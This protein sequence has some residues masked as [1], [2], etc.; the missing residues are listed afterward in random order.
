LRIVVIGAGDIGMPV[1]HY[2]SEM[3]NILTVIEKDEKRCKHISDHADAAIFKGNAT[4]PKIWNSIE[5]DKADALFVLTNSDDAN[6][7]ACEI[8]K[9][10]FGIPFVIARAHQPESID[11]IKEAGG[12]VVICPSLETRRLFLNALESRSAETLYE[13][14]AANYKLVAVTVPPN[15]TIIGK[16]L[17]K[18]DFSENCRIA[19]VFRNGGFEFPAQSFM[20]KG[21]DRVLVLGTIEDVEKATKKLID[22]EVT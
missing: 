21:G 12:D 19:T 18:I 11:K 8:A 13:K 7:K 20:F 17:G 5:A 2:L 9:K 16:T 22:V 4:N 14:D 10:Q 3:G 15:G 6:I 1:I